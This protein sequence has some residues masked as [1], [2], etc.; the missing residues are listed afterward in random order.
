MHGLGF[1]PTN[2]DI[3]I[4]LQSQRYT[5]DVMPIA[6][7]WSHPR[8]KLI[9]KVILILFACFCIW[10]MTVVAFRVGGVYTGARRLCEAVNRR[11]FESP[12]FYYAWEIVSIVVL[13][14]AMTAQFLAV[15]FYKR[16][17]VAVAIV[18]FL[19]SLLFIWGW[20]STCTV[21]VPKG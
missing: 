7:I 19:F 6:S 13:L 1:V 18:L 4:A 9:G 8:L 17:T 20:E 5:Y 2:L 14:V 12:R 3:G 11:T 21:P 10:Q 16:S 15:F